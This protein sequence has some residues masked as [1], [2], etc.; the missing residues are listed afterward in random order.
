MGRERNEKFSVLLA[1][2]NCTPDEERYLLVNC[3][4]DYCSDRDISSAFRN[5]DLCKIALF[6]YLKSNSGLVSLH[7]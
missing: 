6:Q 7:L 4:A 2:F 1:N 3:D 5:Q